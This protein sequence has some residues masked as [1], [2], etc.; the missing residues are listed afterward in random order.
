[1][2]KIMIDARMSVQLAKL[3]QVAVL[4]DTTGKV[5]GQFCPRL[6]S[7]ASLEPQISEKEIKRR[8]KSREKRNSTT[9]VLEHLEKLARS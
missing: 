5:L 9:E 3:R 4:C 8:L 2:K 6:N 1:M 7:H